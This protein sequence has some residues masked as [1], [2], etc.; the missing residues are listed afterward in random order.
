M[1][2]V[3]VGLLL[4][5]LMGFALPVKI[6]AFYSRYL[7]IAVVAALDTALGGMRAALQGSFDNLIFVSGFFTNTILAAL[8]TYAGDQLGVELYIAAL[9]ALGYRMFQNLGAIRR[10]VLGRPMM[11][12]PISGEEKSAKR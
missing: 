7:S 4:G 3:L 9:F 6:P 5:L 10:L 12:N 11:E 1:I 8:L 2:T